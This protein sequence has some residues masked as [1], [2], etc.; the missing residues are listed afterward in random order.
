[1]PLSKRI[2]SLDLN[3]QNDK[4]SADVYNYNFQNHEIPD[5]FITPPGSVQTTNTDELV[6]QQSSTYMP[7]LDKSQN[8]IYFEPNEL[9][10]NLYLER[11]SRRGNNS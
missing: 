11:S 1:M 9:L 7:S 3:Q 10:F 2:N 8:P 6:R 4:H 5:S